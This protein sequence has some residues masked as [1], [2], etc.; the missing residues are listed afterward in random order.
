MSAK[1]ASRVYIIKSYLHVEIGFF[2]TGGIGLCEI[3]QKCELLLDH[4]Y[5]ILAIFFPPGTM[6]F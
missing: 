4:I 6:L 5:K 3:S 1:L 2:L